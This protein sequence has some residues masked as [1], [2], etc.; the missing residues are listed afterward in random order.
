MVISYISNKGQNCKVSMM[1]MAKCGELMARLVDKG[2]KITN[3]LA[4]K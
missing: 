4:V 1:D 2:C 3:V